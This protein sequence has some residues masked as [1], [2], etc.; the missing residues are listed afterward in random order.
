M[1]LQSFIKISTSDNRSLPIYQ[2]IKEYILEK[3]ATGEWRPNYKIPSENEISEA[4][5]VSRMTVNRAFKELTEEGYLFREKGAG[6]FV[7]EP[8]QLMP[9]FELLPISQEIAIEGDQFAAEIIKKGKVLADQETLKTFF[10][11][12]SQQHI[13]EPCFYSE[14]CYFSNGQPIQYEQRYVLAS[15]APNYLKETFESICSATY[16]QKLSP[17]LSQQHILEAIIPDADLRAILDTGA[18]EAGFKV[19]EKLKINHK[20]V[21]YA[22][23]YYPASRYKFHSKIE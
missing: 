1:T 4:I 21:S 16:L 6:T 7:A 3:I 11:I 13:Q 20:I 22:K 19:T 15:F 5:N 14:I 10:G 17:I 12:D 23:Q 2:Q 9:F 18:D 8:F